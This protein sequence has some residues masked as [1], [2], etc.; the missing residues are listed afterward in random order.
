VHHHAKYQRGCA[1][2]LLRC[3]GVAQSAGG[4]DEPSAG[5]HADG[6]CRSHGVHAGGGD[7]HVRDGWYR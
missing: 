1:D 2:Q 5:D 6:R 3:D 4:P 7:H